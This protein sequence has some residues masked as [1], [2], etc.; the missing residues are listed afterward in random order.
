MTE[1]GNWVNFVATIDLNPKH[2]DC[3]S[4]QSLVDT[5]WLLLSKLASLQS[6]INL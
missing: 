2:M 4:N 3:R 5:N 1:L 6:V